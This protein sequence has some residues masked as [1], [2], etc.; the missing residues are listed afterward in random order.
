MCCDGISHCV[1]GC[2]WQVRGGRWKPLHYFYKSS[3]MTD[4]MATCGDL[5]SKIPNPNGTKACYISNHGAGL[6]FA[7]SVTL[8]AYENFGDGT[9]VVVVNKTVALSEGPGALEWFEVS[10]VKAV[11]AFSRNAI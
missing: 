11:K 8:S 7:G 6:T 2:V 4:V 10:A 1:Y 9:A 3:L 5:S